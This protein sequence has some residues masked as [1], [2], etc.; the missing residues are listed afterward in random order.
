MAVADDLAGALTYERAADRRCCCC[1]E[2]FRRSRRRTSACCCRRRWRR[3]LAF[4]ALHLAGKLPVVLNW[5]TG[6]ANL[7]T[8]RKLM[9]LTHVVTS[10]AFIDRTRDRGRRDA[11]PVP[12]RRCGR[13]SASLELLRTL[14]A[15]RCFGRQR[16]A[17]CVPKLTRTQPAVVLF[18]SGSE[19]APKAVP[20]THRNIISDQ[21]C[22]MQ[23]AGAD[24]QATS[25]LGFL[26]LFHS[27]GLTVTG[28]LPLLYGHARRPPPR[29]DRRRRLAARSRRTSRRSWPARRRSSA[30][31]STAPSRA[32]WT[33]CG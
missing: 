5:T 30:T 14:L 33:R 7:A 25:V 20:L 16:S 15:V 27:F 8:P 9:G 18:T 11:V 19:K 24:A 28:L 22:G 6:P 32:S 2:R 21:R 10:K 23:R 3:D 13:R 17:R 26:P 31:S 1:A 12:R 29:P 4:L